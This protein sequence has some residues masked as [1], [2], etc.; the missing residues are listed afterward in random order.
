MIK[1]IKLI[2]N[3]GVFKDFKWDSINDLCVFNQRNII[4]GWNYSGKTT[5]SRVFSSI[6]DKK[7]HNKYK[8]SEFILTVGEEGYE[9]S[10]F[11]LNK[12]PYEVQVFN[13]DYIKENLK[14][15]MNDKI[16]AILFDIGGNVKL[17]EKID[18]G[19]G[20]R[21]RGTGTLSLSRYYV[22][23]IPR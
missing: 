12:F 16:N 14:W 19:R 18:R 21:D 1:K 23:I 11:E 2:K 5:I 10:N 13:T 15:E 20:T 17:R 9:I 3:F 8:N 6:R 7:I 22:T 4:Y